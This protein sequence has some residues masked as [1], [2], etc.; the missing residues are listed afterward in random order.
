V[1]YPLYPADP[2][3][4]PAEP[5]RNLDTGPTTQTT[6]MPEPGAG[7]WDEV[8]DV[9][10]ITAEEVA[11]RQ[12]EAFGG[13]KIGSA[14]FGWLTTAAMAAILTGLGAVA[15]EVLGLGVTPDPWET[16][17]VA[18]LD[19]ASVG[20][21]GAGLLIAVV[22][23]SWYCGGY[24]AGRMARFSGVAQ[25]IAVWVW[26]IVFGIAA[27]IVAVMLDGRYGVLAA[28]TQVLPDV[29]IPNGALTVSWI[30]AAV[31]L[32]AASLGGAVLGGAVG[33]RYH[34]RIDRIG[35]DA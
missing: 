5:F 15:G 10:P 32:S 20:W 27:A 22:L 21:I 17:G 12:R 26:A 16:D 28:L 6:T 25:G 3:R 23:L 30:I 9:R 33:V 1:T 8:V 19:A 14:F 11:E 29:P 31:T 18:G 4:D 13:P 2:T 24:V 35:L 7:T 34:R